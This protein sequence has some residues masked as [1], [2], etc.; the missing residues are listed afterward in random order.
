M[1]NLETVRKLFNENKP[2]VDFCSIRF[3]QD[4]SRYV[5]AER[6]VL[7]PLSQSIDHGY[8]VIIFDKGGLGYAASADVSS[9][10]VKR[11]LAEARKW[12][13]FSRQFPLL[14]AGANQQVFAHPRGEF[15]SPVNT[16]YSEVPL[17]EKCQLVLKVNE[18]LKVSDAIVNWEAS[19]MEHTTERL[20]LTSDGG[21]VFQKF[22]RILPMARA[23][24]E[25]DGDVQSRSFGGHAFVRQMGWEWL[26]QSGLE[27]Q[28][29]TIAEEAIALS[30]ADNCVQGT[31][32]VLI[33]P[34][35]M[36]LQIHESIGHPVEL[37][38]ILGDE[39]NYAGTS[40]VKKE[41]FGNFQYGSSLLN[42]TFDPSDDSQCCSY[43]F[44]DEGEKATKE[45]IIR[46]GKL[47]RPLGGTL[48][49][50]RSGMKGV[51]NSRAETWYRPPIDRM[52]NLNVECGES[53]YEQ[54][55]ENTERGVFVKTNVSWS[56][57]D[58]RNKFQFGCEWGQMIENGK[59]TKV[60]KN[61][62][63]RGISASFWRSLKMVGNRQTNQVMG[64][65]WCG[66]GEP[67]QAIFVGHASPA[68]LFTDVEVFGGV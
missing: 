57:D 24:A 21:E 29:K 9:E 47:L 12:C 27:Q 44:D 6:G 30:E 22:D 41:M 36:I 13:D 31:M 28:A 5:G 62:N 35:Q 20:Y 63:Y 45:Y 8:M 32:D 48:S 26:G 23:S 7:S 65:P 43:N 37:D 59:L 18:N 17:R 1:T 49:Q 55:I 16:A 14:A 46:E 54:M 67:N 68:C 15:N 2:N 50:L 60:V 56:I 38:R 66:K 61:P 25:K 40:F 39:R 42:V 10:G 64:T 3:H 58:S 51:A 33:A 11:A 52:A 4:E 53:S 19:V 34:D